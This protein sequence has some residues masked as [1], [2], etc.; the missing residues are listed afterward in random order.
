MPLVSVSTPVAVGLVMAGA[1][2]PEQVAWDAASTVA[3]F[4]AVMS[5]ALLGLALVKMIAR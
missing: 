5:T 2:E 1:V 4:V 3:G